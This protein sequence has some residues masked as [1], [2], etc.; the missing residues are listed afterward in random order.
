MIV[1]ARAAI[2]AMFIMV[3]PAVVAAARGL[4]MH[5]A[6]AAVGAVFPKVAQGIGRVRAAVVAIRILGIPA[7]VGAQRF[8]PRERQ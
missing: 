4:L 2:V 5:M 7:I 1:I 6:H 3:P 8:H